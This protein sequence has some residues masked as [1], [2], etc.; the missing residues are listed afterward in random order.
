[1]AKNRNF[2]C[3][4]SKSAKLRILSVNLLTVCDTLEYK[5]MSIYIRFL[6]TFAILF[7]NFGYFQRLKWPFWTIFW[8]I[9]AFKDPKSGKFREKIGFSE[10]TKYPLQHISG[11]KIF[12]RL[13]VF[14][15]FYRGRIK[16]VRPTNV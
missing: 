6:Q 14:F 5:L 7:C 2:W 9:S 10:R 3:K 13:C 12:L 8:P 16:S 4:K 1:M 15:R 11:Y